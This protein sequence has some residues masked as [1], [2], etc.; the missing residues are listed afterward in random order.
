MTTE[1][2]L[3][4]QLEPRDIIGIAGLADVVALLR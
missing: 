2:R 4:R 1:E 3:G